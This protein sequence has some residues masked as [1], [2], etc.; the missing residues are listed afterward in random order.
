MNRIYLLILAF[1]M[2]STVALN[3]QNL[4]PIATDRPDQ[5][6]C[7][8][9][10]PK[11]FLQAENG[12]VYEKINP[13]SFVK[14]H[15]SILWKYG[16]SDKF[17]FRLIAEIISQKGENQPEKMGLTPVTV[18]FKTNI[19]KE[20]GLLP[21]VSF[22]GHLNI[23]NWASSEFQTNYF[24]PSFRF[25]M[26]H[27]LSEKFTLAYNLGAEWD[28]ETP[29]TTF[30]YTLTS[31][32]SISKKLGVY[33]EFYGFA[34][35]LQAPDHRFDGGV[36]YLINSNIMVDISGGF[37]LTKNAPMHYLSFGFSYRLKIRKSV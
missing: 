34:P 22:I 1:I 33:L 14:A 35:Q 7:P 5:T 12:L 16:V 11:G 4:A 30:I 29:Q 10:V 31:G 27:T 15:P 20:K 25:T 21:L 13:T 2:G 36:T 32:Y 26:Q 24:A 3:C 17:E 18:G 23:P 8:F 19:A 37:G 9:I 6:E 28:G